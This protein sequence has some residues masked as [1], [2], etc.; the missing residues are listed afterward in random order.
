MMKIELRSAR[1]RVE[2]EYFR[3][4]SVLRGDVQSGCRQVRT[5][6]EI[7]SDAPEERLRLL[8]RNAKG[9]CFAESMVR[10]A[11]PL[12]SVITIN[13]KETDLPENA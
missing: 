9:G 4:G 12:K 11:V 6:F 1:V 10:T 5:R 7:E 2:M 13:G 3:S 8:V